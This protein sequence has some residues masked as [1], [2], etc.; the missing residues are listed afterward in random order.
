[1][2][3]G[4]KHA[5][6]KLSRQLASVP[7]E[8]YRMEKDGRKWKTV[9]LDRMALADWLGTHGDGDGSRIFPGIATMANKFGWSRRKVCYLLDDL[10]ELRLLESTPHYSRLKRTRI[11]QMNLTAFLTPPAPPP[12][13]PPPGPGVQD[14]PAEE[15]NIQGAGVQ[16]STLDSHSQ[17]CNIQS[18]ECKIETQECKIDVQECKHTLHTTVTLTDTLTV[19]TEGGAK[20]APQ[21]PPVDFLDALCAHLDSD[22]QDQV[23]KL[24]E[25]YHR[26]LDSDC[27]EEKTDAPQFAAWHQLYV[28]AARGLALHWKDRNDLWEYIVNSYR[29]PD[30]E[31]RERVR[32]A[33]DEYI[34]QVRMR[35]S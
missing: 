15:S 11:R 10:G 9:A 5:A 21:V 17:E 20:T 27:F 32:T 33:T 12:P 7:V 3:P 16:H 6:M 14:S 23:R 22:R 2:S 31:R 8:K 13:P 24:V 4:K 26:L 30:Q 29:P 19:T 35:R 1:M 18:E 34:A 28:K 25:H